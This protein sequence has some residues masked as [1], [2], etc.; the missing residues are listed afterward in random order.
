MRAQR[1]SVK[2]ENA[3]RLNLLRAKNRS[4]EKFEA[5]GWMFLCFLS[6]LVHDDLDSARARFSRE[7]AA[8]NANAQRFA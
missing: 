5:N 1:R 2:I 7:R 4:Y 6:R 3:G 8:G